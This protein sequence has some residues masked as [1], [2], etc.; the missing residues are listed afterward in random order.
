MGMQKPNMGL[1]FNPHILRDTGHA[2]PQNWRDPL[3]YSQKCCYLIL[4]V[5]QKLQKTIK[6]KIQDNV[7]TVEMYSLTQ[8]Y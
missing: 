8:Y 6:M 4:R 5:S 1:D 7:G 3:A 2:Q